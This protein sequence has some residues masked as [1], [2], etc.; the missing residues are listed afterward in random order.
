VLDNINLTIQRTEFVAITGPSGSGKTTLLKLLGG[1]LMP[2]RGELLV[3]GIPL[4]KYGIKNYRS[5]LGIASQDDVLFAGTLAENIAFFDPDYA[6]GDVVSATKAAGVHDEII[7]FPMGYETHIND[8]GSNL[9]GGQ[10]QR[11]VLA[12]ALYQ[13]PR[14]FLLDEA[15]AHLD[16]LTERNVLTNIAGKETGCVLVT[17]RPD[18]Y[19]QASRIITI[20]HGGTV[21]MRENPAG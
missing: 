3:D 18:A 12:R 6:I 20:H 15:T 13:K 16:V 9:S 1:L 2:T 4:L 7:R 11:I 8:M 5:Q 10:R 21:E 19:G 17:H 14:L